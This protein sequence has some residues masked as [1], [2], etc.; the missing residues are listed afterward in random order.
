MG[1][2]RIILIVE[3]DDELRR[4]WRNTLA[5]EGFDV[6]EAGDG[7]SAL[8][9]L[10]QYLPHLVVLDLGLPRLDGLSVQQEI[11]AQVI[12]RHIPVVIVTG[13]AD[14]LDHLNVPCVLRKPVSVD[15]LIGTIR[16]CLPAGAPRVHA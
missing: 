4:L 6:L 8:H 12:T 10:D 2:Q 7:I 15:N 9:I 16:K 14:D 1:K 5:C 13:S 11:A 3:D